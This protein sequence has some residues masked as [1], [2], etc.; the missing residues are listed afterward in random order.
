AIGA[1]SVWVANTAEQTVARFDPG[2]GTILRKISVGSGPVGIA[3]GAGAVWVADSR[4]GTIARID[5]HSTSAPPLRRIGGAP[6]ELSVGGNVW[7][8]VLPAAG[9]HL[10]G[11]L[12]IGL[13]PSEWAYPTTSLEPASWANTIQWTML[14]MTNDGLVTYRRTGGQAGGALVPDLA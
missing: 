11:T 10:G 4:D 8:S 1:G 5:P 14:S 2:S 13:G 7:S 9:T 12:T 3:Y 6:T